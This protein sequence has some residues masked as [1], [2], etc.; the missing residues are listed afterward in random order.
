MR[1]ISDRYSDFERSGMRPNWLYLLVLTLLLVSSACSF[2]SGETDT[3]APSPS[4]EVIQ[5]ATATLPAEPTPTPRP[6]P[7]D[8]VESDP[9]PNAELGLDESVI[10][11]FN[12]SMDRSSV[13]TAF[14]G[15]SGS[16]S[17]IDDS[18]LIFTPD[19]PLSPATKINLGIDTQARAANGLAL[20]EPISLVYHAVGYL[21]LSQTVPEQGAM[22]VDP[23]GQIVATFNRPIVPLG[24]DQGDLP[25]AFSLEPDVEGQGEWLNTSTYI[26]SPQ[27]SLAGGTE[28][29][30]HIKDDLVSLDGT[31]LQIRPPWSFTTA[32]P[33][34]VSVEPDD[35]AKDVSLD[36]TILLR[37]KRWNADWYLLPGRFSNN[38]RIISCR[39]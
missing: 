9:F 1:L 30:V 19:T 35:G 5:Q 20:V 26:F 33:N 29:S 28:Y 3:P 17:W 25:A 18:T 37:F 31:P 21:N 14:S 23:A 8:L 15:L 36:S 6:L 7:P 11:Y 13:E 27:P 38:S 24:A 22:G 2:P 32:E 34:L 12:Q 39:Q 16:F 10:F 4:Q